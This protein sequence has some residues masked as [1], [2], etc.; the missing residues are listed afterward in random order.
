MKVSIDIR[1]AVFQLW[2]NLNARRYALILFCFDRLRRLWRQFVLQGERFDL[3][4]LGIGVLEIGAALVA[5]RLHGKL[6]VGGGYGRAVREPGFRPDLERESLPVVGNIDGLGNQ[7]V[8]R[9]GFVP[10]A[11]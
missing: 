4:D 10:V 3:G 7:A 2:V 6:D 5:Q 11:P 8:K 1:L 9:K